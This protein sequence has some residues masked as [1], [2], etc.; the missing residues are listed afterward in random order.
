M[1]NEQAEVLV[2]LVDQED[3]AHLK[4]QVIFQLTE[5]LVEDLVDLGAGGERGGKLVE[6]GKVLVLTGQRAVARR[7]ITEQPGIDNGN[8]SV[9]GEDF[10]Q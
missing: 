10:C 2:I 6:E 5:P 9:L 1:V 4:P 3:L 8:R 7:I